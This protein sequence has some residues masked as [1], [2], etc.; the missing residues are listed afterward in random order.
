[1]PQATLT[2]NLPEE[3][4]E[5]RTALNGGRYSLALGEIIKEFRD[6]LKY[7]D[8]LTKTQ[9]AVYEEL[10]TKIHRIIEDNRISF[11]EV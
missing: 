9:R 3:E 6:T 1:M 7:R 4:S 8:D 5:F 10:Q 11:D 2:F